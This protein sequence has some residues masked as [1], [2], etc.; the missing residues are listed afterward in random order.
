MQTKKATF[1]KKWNAL[2]LEQ[3]KKGISHLHQLKSDERIIKKIYSK[4]HDPIIDKF[5]NSYKLNQWSKRQ[6]S[7]DINNEIV[8]PYSCKLINYEY[9]KP[10]KHYVVRVGHFIKNTTIIIINTVNKFMVN[11]YKKVE[12]DYERFHNVK[13][14]SK[15]RG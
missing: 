6:R 3:K 1:T 9:K 7:I 5:L 15:Y 12:K 11:L 14:T 13:I 10:F 2:S 8:L 4:T